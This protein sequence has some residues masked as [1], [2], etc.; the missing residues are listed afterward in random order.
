M[1]TAD[2]LRELRADVRKVAHAPARGNELCQLREAAG[3]SQRKI[4]AV[5]GVSNTSIGNWERDRHPGRTAKRLVLYRRAIDY[6]AQELTEV[7]G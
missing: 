7:A 2:A 3:L 4:A 5:L 6:L 1:D